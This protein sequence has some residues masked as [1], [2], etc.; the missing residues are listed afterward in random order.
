MLPIP[1]FPVRAVTL[2]LAAGL[3]ACAS[4]GG[5]DDAPR[6]PDPASASRHGGTYPNPGDLHPLAAGLSKD[7]LYAL[8]GP[9]HFAEGVFGVREWDYLFNFREPDGQVARCQ[10]KL[11]F[12]DAGTVR[13]LHWLPAT[14]ASRAR[15]REPGMGGGGAADAGGER[16][17]LL[18]ADTTFAFASAELTPLGRRTLDALVERAGA[19]DGVE[20]IEIVGHADRIGRPAANDALSRRR[21]EAVREH[22]AQ[23]G[24]PAGRISV[25]GRGSREP[26][27]ACAGERG[28]DEVACLA[29]NRRVEVLLRQSRATA[30]AR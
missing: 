8:V 23:R 18:S 22:L 16:V 15:P 2:V 27:V 30:A 9:P 25:E 13:D 7:Q 24:G 14:C 20:A 1:S 21:A 10:L 5:A 17:A 3:A 6:F 26:V 19:F 29:P 4:T 12:D 11:R 28:A